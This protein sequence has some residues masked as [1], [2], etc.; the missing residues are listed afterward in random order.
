MKKKSKPGVQQYSFTKKLLMEI[1][2][3]VFI[4]LVSVTN[5]FATHTYSQVAKVTLD[6][7]NKPLGQVMD[8]IE[9][10]SEFYFIFNQKQ[11]DVEKL[12]TVRKED[13]LI[14]GS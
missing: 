12:V 10:Q 1:K 8:E 5:L 11:I 7:E 4:V 9:S 14:D 3:T 6:M 13:I 2:I